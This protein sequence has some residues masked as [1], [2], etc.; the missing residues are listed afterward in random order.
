MINNILYY[1][2]D[3]DDNI[4]SMPTKIIVLNNYGEEVGISTEDF[5][6]YRHIIGIE[7]FIYEGHTIVS[8]PLDE[9]GNVDQDK[10]Y[11]NFTDYSD[12]NLFLEDVKYALNNNLYG[13]AWED[14]VEC[15]T[16]GS[17]FSII[18]ARGHESNTIKEVI[19]FI[20]N[21]VLT[22][23]QKTKMYN[24]LLD[25]SYIFNQDKKHVFSKKY[26][27]IF[28]ENE[29]VKKYLRSC[30]YVGISSPS[31]GGQPSSTEK[32]KGVAIKEFQNK[33]NAFGKRVGMHVKLGFSDDDLKNVKHIEDLFKELDHE[34]FSHII[35]YTVKN[36]NNPNNITKTITDIK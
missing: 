3:W 29:L 32:A 11:R 2:F 16:N 35:Q 28:T 7:K 5:A 12:E 1:C 18:T 14:F 8:Y 22:I 13:P 36:T 31:R 17:L 27:D 9:Q 26:T 6:K 10:A 24:S 15:L 30:D 23:E 4:L 33:I 34:E 25:F 19:V 21:N 20:L